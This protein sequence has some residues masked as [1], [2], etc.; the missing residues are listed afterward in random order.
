LNTILNLSTDKNKD[1]LI[2]P[3]IFF[4]LYLIIVTALIFGCTND[5][6]DS[7]Q[8]VDTQAALTK[9]HGQVQKTIDKLASGGTSSQELSR[10]NA[11][12]GIVRVDSTGG[13]HCYVYLTEISDA[14]IATVRANM[15]TVEIINEELKIVQ[16]W[17]YYNDVVTLARL[18]FVKSITPPEYGKTL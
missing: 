1:C 5:N 9:I 4:R 13:I 14:R 7:N 8:P 16:G 3:S 11:G 15:K 2:M 12:T 17:I 10:N 6:I 18:P